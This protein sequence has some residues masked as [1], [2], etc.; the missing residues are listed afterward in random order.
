MCVLYRKYHFLIQDVIPSD[1][2]ITANKGR[3]CIVPVRLSSTL[4]TVQHSLP[5]RANT[6]GLLA[7]L[8]NIN[9]SGLICIQIR[10]LITLR[11]SGLWYLVLLVVDTST[12]GETAA[13]VF[14]AE[15][16][17]F[18]INSTASK[19]KGSWNCLSLTFLLSCYSN[20]PDNYDIRWRFTSPAVP[21]VDIL[22]YPYFCT[23]SKCYCILFYFCCLIMWH[24]FN[25]VL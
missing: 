9:T 20:Q 2:F 4:T 19:F 23:L 24:L 5:Y 12:S 22:W 18:F 6:A 8:Q 15:T 16:S 1:I 7:A 13:S 10:R 25:I 17:V 11:S 14:E 3:I 21:D